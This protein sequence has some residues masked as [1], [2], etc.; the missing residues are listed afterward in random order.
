M[1]K[2]TTKDAE[3]FKALSICGCATYSQSRE[4]LSDKRLKT[5]VKSGL[6]SVGCYRDRSTKSNVYFYKLT[7]SGK[8]A[9]RVAGASS[10]YSSHAPRHDVQIMQ[11]YM[12]LSSNER[13]TCITEG[14]AREAYGRHSENSGGSPPD[15]AYVSDSGGLV[16]FEVITSNY[17]SSMISAKQSFSSGAGATLL[18]KKI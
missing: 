13:S 3:Y 15:L 11:H 18:T 10:F 1:K 16:F 6:I 5:L 8:D 17:T 12:G 7:K 4:L 9:A 14:Q 2:M